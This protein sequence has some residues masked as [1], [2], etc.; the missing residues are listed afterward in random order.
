M[1]YECLKVETFDKHMK[2]LAKIRGEQ[3]LMAEPE[4][5]VQRSDLSGKTYSSRP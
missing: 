1:Y 2:E 3:G 5:I 4:K